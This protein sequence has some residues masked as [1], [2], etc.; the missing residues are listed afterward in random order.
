MKAKDLLKKTSENLETKEDEEEDINEAYESLT[1]KIERIRNGSEEGEDETDD[2]EQEHEQPEE[3]LEDKPKHT[4][5]R[6]ELE[7][8]EEVDDLDKDSSLSEEEIA[9]QNKQDLSSKED[10]EET[11]EDEALE[12]QQP[13]ASEENLDDLAEEKIPEDQADDQVNPDQIEKQR[14]EEMEKDQFDIPNLKNRTPI[15][16]GYTRYDQNLYSNQ[17]SSSNSR[18]GGRSS[19]LHIIILLLIGL[20]VIGGTVYVL[21]SQFG[22]SNPSPTPSSIAES[23]PTPSPSPSLTPSVDRSKFKIRVLNGTTKSGLAASVSAKLKNLG[24]QTDKTSNATNSAFQKT[25]IKVKQAATS[26]IDQ[27][28]KDLAPDFDASGTSDLKDSDSA[29][30]E[31]ILGQK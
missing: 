27:L 25:V 30:G 21:K 2:K 18:S 14:Q 6:K 17:Y 9:K 24:Y 8:D 11:S 23:T 20:A 1:K 28:V 3:S 15:N 10:E 7:E 22:Q 26:L 12:S 5:T 19:K 29:D 16:T 4:F 31:V 13:S